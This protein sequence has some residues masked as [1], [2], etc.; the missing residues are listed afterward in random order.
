MAVGLQGRL[1]GQPPGQIRTCPQPASL[2]RNPVC[3]LLLGDAPA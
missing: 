1:C 2:G 3:A